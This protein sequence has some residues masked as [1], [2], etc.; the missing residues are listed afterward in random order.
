M[1]LYIVYGSNE[2]EEHEW[3]NN[4]FTEKPKADFIQKH[5]T[6]NE[7]PSVTWYVKEWDTER[8]LNLK[9]DTVEDLMQQVTEQEGS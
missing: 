4:I 7:D 8:P 9:G 5:L 1:K 3:V 2:E 6:E